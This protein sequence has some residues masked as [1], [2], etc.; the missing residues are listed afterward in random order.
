MNPN[1]PPA[2]EQFLDHARKT[3]LIDQ[4]A[5]SAFVMV[6]DADHPDLAVALQVGV[7]VMLDKPL[8]FVYN[9][10]EKLSPRVRDLADEL[11]EFVPGGPDHPVN[12]AKLTAA[13]TRMSEKVRAKDRA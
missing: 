8:L 5:A 6:I 2:I 3:G 12:K 1:N 4:I 9:Q 10:G 7:A 13:L 11:V